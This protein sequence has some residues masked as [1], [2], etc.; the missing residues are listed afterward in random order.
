MTYALLMRLVFHHYYRPLDH[1]YELDI[2]F[3]FV[4]FR[5]SN[6]LYLLLLIDIVILFLPKYSLLICKIKK[7]GLKNDSFKVYLLNYY[8]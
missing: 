7:Y 8:Y 3:P 6:I 4:D 1:L 2:D 5:F